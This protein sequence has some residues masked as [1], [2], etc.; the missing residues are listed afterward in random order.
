VTTVV[1]RPVRPGTVPDDVRRRT[2]WTM[3]VSV[4]LHVLLFAFVL[5]PRPPVAAA[6]ARRCVSPAA[7]RARVERRWRSAAA[8][9]RT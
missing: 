7:A 2:R 6:R 9:A 3:G 5:A 4:A 1:L 8:A